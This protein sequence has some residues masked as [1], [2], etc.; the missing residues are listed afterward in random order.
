[1]MHGEPVPVSHIALPY[2]DRV[3]GVRLAA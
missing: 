3:D 1:L 2:S